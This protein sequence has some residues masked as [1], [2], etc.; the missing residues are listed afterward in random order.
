MI[1]IGQ[2]VCP[3]E[4]YA[5]LQNR[6]IRGVSINKEAKF[7]RQSVQKEPTVPGK[8]LNFFYKTPNTRIES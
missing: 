1:Q 7:L 5:L 4:R 8:T 3:L 2:R 6:I